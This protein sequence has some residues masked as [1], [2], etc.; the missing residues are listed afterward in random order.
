[1]M[2]EGDEVWAVAA[3]SDGKWIASGGLKKKV[4][5]WNAMTHEKV[6]ELEGH[7]DFV[8]SLDFSPDSAR[9]VSGSDDTTVIVW[10]TT[11]GEPL[12]T[13]TGHRDRHWVS[14]VRVSPNGNNIASCAWENDVRIWR[15]DSGK[16]VIPPIEVKAKSLAWTT[17]G[18]RLIVGC[19]DGSIK[20]YDSSSGSL[21]A[22]C[23]GHASLVR[24]IAVSPND[25]FFASASWDHT[26]RLW[27]STTR[28]QIGLALQH[29]NDV[30]SV[31]ISPDGSHLVSG[32]DDR[33]VHI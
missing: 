14:S 17:D 15:S 23:K 30:N 6:V 25:K 9:V 2:M 26:V 33:K 10:S 21:L 11:T 20:I 28:Q 19:E 8:R 27:D 12:A 31:A 32:G 18:Q 7:S 24:S 1:M 3:S 5:I 16:L 4:T 29:D 22:E 13:F